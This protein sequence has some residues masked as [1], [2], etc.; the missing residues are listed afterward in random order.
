MDNHNSKDNCYKTSN[1]KYFDCPPRMDDGRHFTD[2][3]GNCYV[4]NVIRNNNDIM[5]SFQY[6]SFLTNNATE[7]MDLN[8][9]YA[10]QKNCCG[11][12]QKPYDQG[13]MLPEQS[14]VSCNASTC[15]IEKGAADGLGQGRAHLNQPLHCPQW[16]ANL[17]ANKGKNY[18]A[19]AGDNH[20]YYPVDKDLANATR[21]AV[22]GGGEMLKGG[23]PATYN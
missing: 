13:T 19:P 20:Q 21:Q 3:R 2:Y 14:R 18:C 9:T 5:N 6:R 8:R 10:C 7:L 11:P 23:D 16:P 1:N 22:P 12:C 15:Q 17:P 4:N